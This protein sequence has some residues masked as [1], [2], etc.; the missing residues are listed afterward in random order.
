MLLDLSVA[1]FQLHHHPQ[2]HI[3]CRM[4]VELSQ[5]PDH[6]DGSAKHFHARF[7]RRALCSRHHAGGDRA[8]SR[9]Q[10]Q[11]CSALRTRGL[12]EPDGQHGIGTQCIFLPCRL[13]EYYLAKLLMDNLFLTQVTVAQKKILDNT[14]LAL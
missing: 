12:S 2:S 9:A 6:K 10:F 1:L 7:P 8:G 3:S 13:G 4:E 5:L 11:H 14:S